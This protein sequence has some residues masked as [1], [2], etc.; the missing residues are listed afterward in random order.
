M[1]RTTIHMII[2]HDENALSPLDLLDA[3]ASYVSDWKDFEVV[4]GRVLAVA[5][6]P[7]ED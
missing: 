1:K 4:T 7:D 6:T 5:K 2:D 3:I